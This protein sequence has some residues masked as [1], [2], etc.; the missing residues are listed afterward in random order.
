[1]RLTH[2]QIDRERILSDRSELCG[3][4]MTFTL[5]PCDGVRCELLCKHFVSTAQLR[6]LRI[7]MNRSLIPGR[8]TDFPFPHSIFSGFGTHRVPYTVGIFSLVLELPEPRLRMNGAKRP[9]PH[10]SI[11]WWLS[12]GAYIF[13]YYCVCHSTE[14]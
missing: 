11:T 6:M 7:P 8:G 14:H 13:T 10:H 2:E 4:D 1:M 5:W 12:T 9:T 3:L